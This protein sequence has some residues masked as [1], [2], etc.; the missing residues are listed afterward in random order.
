MPTKV[1]MSARRFRISRHGEPPRRAHEAPAWMRSAAAEI[2]AL[3]RRPVPRTGRDR[4]HEED[5]VQGHLPVIVAALGQTPGPLQVGGSHD[6]PV[7]DGALEVRRV[8]GQQVH[9]PIPQGGGVAVIPGPFPQPVGR[10]L[11]RDRHDVLARRGHCGIRQRWDGRRQPGIGR[12]ASVLRV[13]VGALQVIEARG[14][15]NDPPEMVISLHVRE[16]GKFPQCQVHLGGDA[17]VADVPQ[18]VGQL[19]VEQRRIDQPEECLPWI[20]TGGHR[21]R[22][23]LLPGL[24]HDPAD[25]AAAYRYAQRHRA[26]YGPSTPRTFR[27]ADSRSTSGAPCPAAVRK[28]PGGRPMC[29]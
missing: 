28:T 24:Q 16:P 26:R 6:L 11:H 1:V 25:P 19:R 18:G 15:R 8:A 27:A 13:V 29:W 22:G 17:A 12:D 2:Q 10:V 23:D 9:H 4:T 7:E 21:P 3:D 20:R 5:L 14:E